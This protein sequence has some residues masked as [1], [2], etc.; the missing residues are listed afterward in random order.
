MH[1]SAQCIL[2]KHKQ[3][4]AHTHGHRKTHVHT[5]VHM[6]VSVSPEGTRAYPSVIEKVVW[7]YLCE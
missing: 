4:H 1:V 3:S 2:C 6:H 5:R 7:I